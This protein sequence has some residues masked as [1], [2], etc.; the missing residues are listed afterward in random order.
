MV[1]AG[2][3]FGHSKETMRSALYIRYDFVVKSRPVEKGKKEKLEF[4]AEE[5]FQYYVKKQD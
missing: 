2:F 4:E 5:H 3:M 1:E